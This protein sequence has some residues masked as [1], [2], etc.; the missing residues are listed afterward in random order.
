E[1]L[2]VNLEFAS[3]EGIAKFGL[4]GAALPNA[5][6][7]CGFVETP[8]AGIF[9]LGT[10]LRDIGILHQVHR[11]GTVW[12]SD[13]NPDGGSGNQSMTMDFAGL[14]N[15]LE[16]PFR[17][18]GGLFGLCE[19][20]LHYGELITVHAGDGVAVPDTKSQPFPY[21]AQQFVADG[22]PHRVVNQREVVEV[23][24]QYREA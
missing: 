4:D 24:E 19:V 22:M 15:G 16:Y 10:V 3:G 20:Y 9:G 5:G 17:Q 11:I 18:H 23:D 6:A 13:R 14:A 7:H 1:R 2:V 21:G 12:Q 8:A